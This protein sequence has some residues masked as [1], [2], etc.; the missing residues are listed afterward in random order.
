MSLPS[1]RWGRRVPR[2]PPPTGSTAPR[3]PPAGSAPDGPVGG[4]RSFTIA[5]SCRTAHGPGPPGR[6][7]SVSAMPPRGPSRQRAPRP[8]R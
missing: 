1:L 3:P 6:H 8:A 4:G 7:R 5:T 2:R